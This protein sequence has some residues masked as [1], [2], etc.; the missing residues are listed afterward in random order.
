MNK[1]L[2]NKIINNISHAVYQVLNEDIQSFDVVDYNEE[3]ML[4]NQEIDTLLVKPKTTDELKK[5]VA[6]RLSKNPQNP[7]LLDIDTSLITDMFGLFANNARFTIRGVYGDTGN[8]YFDQYRVYAE[9]IN[10]LDLSTWNTSNVTNMCNMFGGIN[11]KQLDLSNFD[12]SNVKTMGFM[13]MGCINLENLD[14]SSFD[15]SNVK[16][17]SYMFRSCESLEK[18]DLSNFDTS[19]VKYMEYMFSYCYNL[20]DLYINNFTTDNVINMTAMF[21]YCKSLTNLNLSNFNTSNVTWFSKMFYN[22]IKVQ[23]INVSRF[24]TRKA[25]NIANMFQNC[26]SL[27]E[28]NIKNFVTSKVNDMNHMFAGCELLEKID[29][30]NFNYDSIKREEK[31][32]LMFSNCHSLKTLIIPYMKFFRTGLRSIAKLCNIYQLN[33]IYMSENDIDMLKEY[34]VGIKQE[35]KVNNNAIEIMLDRPDNKILKIIIND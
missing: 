11:V 13:F 23:S 35:R 16:D 19:N 1:Q 28:I 2:Y 7:Y 5:I 29:L 24:N 25:L 30:T 34:L 12:T 33:V 31:I 32:E 15:T 6:E 22:C 27:K 17:M 26:K 20:Y 18:L 8:E 10:K 21:I 9:D 4:S 3:D 14:I